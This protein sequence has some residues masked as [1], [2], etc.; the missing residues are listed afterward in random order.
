MLWRFR[1]SPYYLDRQG[2]RLGISKVLIDRSRHNPE[3]YRASTL[4]GQLAERFYAAPKQD[5]V[6][7]LDPASLAQIRG[8][9][10]QCEQE[11]EKLH[12]LAAAAQV[13][14]DEAHA[15]FGLDRPRR[16]F[17][18]RCEFDDLPAPAELSPIKVAQ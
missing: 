8:T 3:I 13:M 9:L 17:G 2:D 11:L 14:I 1:G 7:V 12:A 4:L 16:S 18:V 6:A 15:A 5:G 10:G